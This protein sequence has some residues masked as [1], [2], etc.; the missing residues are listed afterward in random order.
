MTD[1]AI[2]EIL[3]TGTGGPGAD[4]TLRKYVEADAPHPPVVWPIERGD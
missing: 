1:D 4:I 3:E 2:I